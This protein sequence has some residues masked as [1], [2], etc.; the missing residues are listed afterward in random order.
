MTDPQEIIDKVQALLSASGIDAEIY[1]SNVRRDEL[2]LD[3]ASGR[4]Y[5]GTDFITLP[6]A[7]IHDLADKYIYWIETSPTTLT[8]KCEWVIHPDDDLIAEGE[9]R[10]CMLPKENAYHL[11]LGEGDQDNHVFRPRRL[12]LKE[13]DPMCP[14]HNKVG[15]VAGFFEWLAMVHK[16]QDGNPEQG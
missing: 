3:S 1:R 14:V 11:Q 2:P 12:R 4:V 10:I 15:R 7:N 13:E 16:E 8:C 6:K 5:E 9:C